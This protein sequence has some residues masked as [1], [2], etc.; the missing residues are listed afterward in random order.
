MGR[1][2]VPEHRRKTA[3]PPLHILSLPLEVLLQIIADIDDLPSLIL[4]SISCSKLR[5]IVD[6]NFL[7][8]LITFYTTDQFLKFAH[9]HLPQRLSLTRRAV[10]EPSTRIN[11]I[12]VVHFVKPPTID[13][14]STPVSI[15]GTY[16]VDTKETDLYQSFVKCLKVLINEAYGLKEVRISEISPQ[17]TLCLDPSEGT[18]KTKKL[19]PHQVRRLEK[20]VLTAQS[21][22]NIPFKTGHVALI[23]CYFDEIQELKLNRFVITEGK[24]AGEFMALKCKIDCLVASAC[25]FSDA[26]RGKRQPAAVFSLISALTM[27]EIH[28]G[29]DLSLIDFVKA[30]NKLTRLSID[31]SS[32]IFYTTDAGNVKQFNFS[33]YNNFFKLVCSGKGGYSLLKEVVLTEF[34]LFDSYGHQHDKLLEMVPEECED[35]SETEVDVDSWVEKPTNTFT[36]F[37]EYLGNVP[38]VTFIVKN[39]PMTMHTCKNCGFTV[40]EAT[41][42]VTSLLPH[43]WAIVL[44]PILNNPNCS[45]MVCDHNLRHLFQRR[46]SSHSIY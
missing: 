16:A 15:A 24:L 21:G 42:P 46:P 7:Y 30:N 36:H 33:K 39:K 13:N 25:K 35:E 2:K 11:Y 44:T 18:S 31:I 28:L 27:A 41:K 5:N 45:V 43:E 6:K 14:T 9:C 10:T 12:Q 20:L 38:F 26:R 8:R 23:S 40:E 4:L 22:W 32:P 1:K 19:L 29:S 34:D 37:L 17:F 3:Y